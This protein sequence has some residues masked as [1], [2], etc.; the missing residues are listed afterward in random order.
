MPHICLPSRLPGIRSL[1][2]FSPSSAGPLLALAQTL[3]RGDSTLSAGERELI[4]AYVSRKN[5]CF[6]CSMSHGAAAQHLFPGG[7]RVVS[8][9]LKNP[10]RAPVSTKLKTLLAIAS[11]VQ[12]GGKHVLKSDVTKA[13]MAGA[14]EKEIHDV[15][16]ISAAFCMYNRYVDGLDSWAPK[17][18]AA[19]DEMGKFLADR[20]YAGR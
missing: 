11:K 3:L 2:A 19:Y 13:R 7:R 5:G 6:F 9:A 1:F 8:A 16:L 15:V 4:A 20:G 12:K 14:S 10:A 18:K 17:R